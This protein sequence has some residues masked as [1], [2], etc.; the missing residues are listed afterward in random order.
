MF[1][2]VFTLFLALILNTN[3]IADPNEDVFAN[4]NYSL[5]KSNTRLKIYKKQVKYSTYYIQ[6]IDVNKAR[7]HFVDWKKSNENFIKSSLTNAW[8]SLNS[9]AYSLSNGSFFDKGANGLYNMSYPYKSDGIIKSMG[10]STFREKDKLKMLSLGTESNTNIFKYTA[11]VFQYDELLFKSISY[12]DVLVGLDPTFNKN[13]SSEIGRNFVG[14]KEYS[15]QENRF[16]PVYKTHLV[17]ILIS[18]AITQ[19]DALNELI[20]LGVYE[21]DI[22]MFDGSESSQLAFF[23]NNNSTVEMYGCTSGDSRCISDKRSIPQAIAVLPR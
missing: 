20:K 6:S 8:K 12:P 3:A 9:R 13:A 23:D 16:S 2:Y 4:N 5:I 19:K 7:I 11:K 15:Y 18:N 10:W 14:V 1:K 22:V 17:Y 21:T